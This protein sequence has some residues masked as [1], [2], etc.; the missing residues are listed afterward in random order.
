MFIYKCRVETISNL[1]ILILKHNSVY[2]KIAFPYLKQIAQYFSFRSSHSTNRKKIT[3]FLLIGT[4]VERSLFNFEICPILSLSLDS[5]IFF[6]PVLLV[7]MYK[8]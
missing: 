2:F 7:T 3:L 8:D 4:E 1:I 6:G 5:P